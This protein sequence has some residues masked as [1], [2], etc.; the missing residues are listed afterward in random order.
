MM[1][2]QAVE[3]H[4]PQVAAS[5]LELHEALLTDKSPAGGRGGG[6]GYEQG[7]NVLA[8]G[9]PWEARLR[10]LAAGE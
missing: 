8:R 3:S 10:E 6:G 9:G 4:I 2:L 5:L 7:G 1:L